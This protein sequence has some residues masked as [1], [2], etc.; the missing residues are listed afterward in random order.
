MPEGPNPGKLQ[1]LPL[2]A[3]SVFPWGNDAIGRATHIDD[4]AQVHT[5]FYDRCGVAAA[6]EVAV[7]ADLSG[8]ALRYF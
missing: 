3:A 6:S 1:R 4:F 8:G 5:A 2:S 7:F